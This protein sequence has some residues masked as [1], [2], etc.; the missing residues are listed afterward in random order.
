MGLFSCRINFDDL[1]SFPTVMNNDVYLW[2]SVYYQVPSVLDIVP[3]SPSHRKPYKQGLDAHR[4]Q[5]QIQLI[6]YTTTCTITT[7]KATVI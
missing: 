2:P 1:G 6:V 3:I 5:F 4:I 7:Y